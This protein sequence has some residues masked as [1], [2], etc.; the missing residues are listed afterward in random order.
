MSVQNNTELLTTIVFERLFRLKLLWVLRE[1]W[2][3]YSVSS[4]MDWSIVSRFAIE[5]LILFQF[6][7]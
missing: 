4:C 6:T 7:S 5:F 2:C 3:C 1:D